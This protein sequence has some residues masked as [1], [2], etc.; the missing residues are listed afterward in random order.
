MFVA[1]AEPQ[2]HPG[3]PTAAKP[4]LL[5]VYRGTGRVDAPQ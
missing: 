4:A 2:V 3:S 1:V 5:L